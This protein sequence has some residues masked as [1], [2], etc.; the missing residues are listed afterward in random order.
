MGVVERLIVLGHKRKGCKIKVFSHTLHVKNLCAKSLFY[1]IIY[2]YK[3]V[4]KN[5]EKLYIF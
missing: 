4:I 3:G 1:N 5:K 2:S